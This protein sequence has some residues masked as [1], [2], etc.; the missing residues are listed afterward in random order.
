MQFMI[1][2]NGAAVYVKEREF[3]LAQ[4]AESPNWDTS[5]WHGPIEAD[6]VE[7][8]RMIGQGMV[9]AGTLKARVAAGA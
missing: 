3:F 2:Y 4:K 5:A 1:H 9:R 7:H 6:G 8:A